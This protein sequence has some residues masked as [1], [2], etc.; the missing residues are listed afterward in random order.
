MM[1]CNCPFGFE[2][3]RILAYRADASKLELTYEFWN[4][5]VG[6]LVFH[7]L[8]GVHDNSAIAVT[9]GSVAEKQDSDLVNLLVRRRYEIPPARLNWRHFQI[10]DLDDQ[11]IL[12]VVAE[13]CSFEAGV[14]KTE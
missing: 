14:R 9:V 11:P 12:E 8:V 3:G 13:S 6:T 2:D 10:L 7:N 4:E 1:I 5:Q